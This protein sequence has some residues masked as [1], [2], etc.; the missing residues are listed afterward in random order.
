MTLLYLYCYVSGDFLY[1]ATIVTFWVAPN[2][3][4]Q[5]IADRDFPPFVLGRWLN[6]YLSNILSNLRTEAASV[7]TFLID[8]GQRRRLKRA[9]ASFRL[10]HLPLVV[11]GL[12]KASQSVT[13]R[14]EGVVVICIFWALAQADRQ[15]S[16]ELKAEI[17]D[18][19]ERLAASE[20]EG[21]SWV[22][23]QD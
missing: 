15:E 4:P 12:G 1:F 23:E 5:M 3:W 7:L 18:L 9:W 8:H 13:L 22:G 20:S 11:L 10:W 21:W 19:K 6:T 16:D 17:E 14:I 2:P